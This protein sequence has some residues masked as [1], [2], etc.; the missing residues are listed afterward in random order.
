MT[1]NE[2][3][4]KVIDFLERTKKPYIVVDEDFL[5]IVTISADD[6]DKPAVILALKDMEQN[7]VVKTMSLGGK[8]FYVLTSGLDTFTQNVELSPSTCSEVTKVI[9]K[10][11]SVIDDYK[12]ECDPK[13]LTEKDIFNLT[14][15]CNFFFDSAASNQGGAK[16][17]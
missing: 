15:I 2:A 7:N 11:C 17:E 8:E 10:F 3:T 9:S 14:I 16:S 12:D 1:I 4:V 13:N 6:S 5:D